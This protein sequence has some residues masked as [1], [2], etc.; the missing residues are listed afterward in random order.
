[1]KSPLDIG[2]S[3]FQ[4]KRLPPAIRDIL[5]DLSERRDILGAVLVKGNMGIVACDLPDVDR[6]THDMPDILATLENWGA[7]SRKIPKNHLFPQ[8]IS[9]GSEFKIFAKRM[10]RDLTLFVIMQN[11]GYIGLATL[12][13]ENT[14][15]KM[16]KILKEDLN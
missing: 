2:I 8:L 6:H 3:K 15:Q 5:S 7:Y 11:S 13:I 16:K 12:D 4:K 9:E 14:I 1:M 10:T